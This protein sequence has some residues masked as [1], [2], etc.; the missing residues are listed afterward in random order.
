MRTK[1][2]PTLRPSQPTSAVSAVSRPVGC[3]HLHPPFNITQPKGW[4][5]FYH[6]TEGRRLSP[7]RWLVTYRGRLPTHRQSPIQV[8]T[9]TTRASVLIVTQHITAE[10]RHHPLAFISLLACILC[11]TEFGNIVRMWKLVSL[12]HYS[13]LILTLMT[14]GPICNIL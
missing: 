11:S 14:H 10:P 4:H 7:P 12:G 8:L 13:V 6:P 9:E 5:S 3:H 1:W 2:L